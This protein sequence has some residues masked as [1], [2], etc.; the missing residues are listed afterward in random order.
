MLMMMTITIET[1]DRIV[2]TPIS[3]LGG[4]GFDSRT[5]CRGV[6]QFLTANAGMVLNLVIIIRFSVSNK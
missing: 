5:G 4:T 3:Y 2:V 1:R 6:F